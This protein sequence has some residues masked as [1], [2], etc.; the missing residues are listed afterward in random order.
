MK[1]LQI[2]AYETPGS[3][4]H[5]LA[6]TP[7]LKEH[8]VDSQHFVWNKD[9]ANPEVLTF[10]DSKTQT[11]QRVYRKLEDVFSL[12]SMIYPYGRK[13]M[14]LSEFNQADLV[15][16]HIIHSGF[17]SFRHLPEL[18]KRKPTIWTLHDPW[19]LTGHCIHPF[20]CERWK[21]GCGNCPDLET[22]FPLR[23]DT[24]KFLF[25]YKKNAYKKSDLNI[26]VASKWMRQMAETSPMLENARI[27]QIPFGLDLDFFSPQNFSE[28]R[29]RFGIP[30]DA[31]VISFRAEDSPYKGLDYIIKALEKLD[32]K[33]PICLLTLSS[34]SLVEKF[35]HRFQVV[36]LGWVN[37]QE[38]VRDVYRASDIFLMPSLA[39]AFGM[40]A[41]EAMA[42]GKPTI[43]FE[44]TAL[45][46][47]TF[48]PDVGIAVPKRDA[49]ALYQALQRLIDDPEERI[50]RGKKAREIAEKVYGEEAHVK[51]IV[52]LYRDVVTRHQT[53]KHL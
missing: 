40:M 29:K 51:A 21:T 15:H 27:H 33:I 46:D 10:N 28:A 18:T 1:I 23:R 36:E 12:Q 22:H 53:N 9:T 3:R 24:T 26:V 4:F 52:D 5:G 19:A 14:N 13:I 42:C 2:N 48:A 17:F 11:M 41:V 20:N 16:L 34:A 7:L 37:D 25:S 50:T 35:S 43:V 47:I 45:P 39:E 49:D 8:G 30:G 31:L 6:S 44:G 32:S 38:I